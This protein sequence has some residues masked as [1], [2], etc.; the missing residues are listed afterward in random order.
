MVAGPMPAYRRSNRAFPPRRHR[1]N[2]NGTRRP[3]SC[4]RASLCSLDS[5]GYLPSGLRLSSID[6]AA[7]AYGMVG[8]DGNRKAVQHLDGGVVAQ[9]LIREG[10]KVKAGQE[11]IRLDQTQPIA[12]LEIQKALL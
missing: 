1:W 2:W 7:I 9:I 4:G 8:A 3:A 6:S 11:L 5:S 12:A 10:D